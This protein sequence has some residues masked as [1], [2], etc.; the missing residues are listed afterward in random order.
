MDI[1]YLKSEKDIRST[2]F[3]LIQSIKFFGFL[4]KN[5]RVSNLSHNG[6]PRSYLEVFSD[7]M[8]KK[9]SMADS[10]RDLIVLRHNFTL[11]DKNKVRWNHYST[12]ISVGDPKN[13]G[14]F[15]AMAKTVGIT[16]AIGARMILDKKIPQKGVISPIY[17]EI[18]NPILK[19]LERLGI[20]MTEES[21]RLEVRL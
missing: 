2:Y 7:L 13:S 15:S 18:Y 6:K 10:D 16:A 5:N 14:G 11:E 20:T 4:S 1:S 17:K 3:G 12:L 21:S 19:E 8:G 9:L